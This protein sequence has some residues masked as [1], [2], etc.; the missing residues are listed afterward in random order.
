VANDGR[1]LLNIGGRLKWI[2]LGRLLS[3]TP[4]ELTDRLPLAVCDEAIA[5]GYPRERACGASF[6]QRQGAGDL[7]ALPG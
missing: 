1:N 2:D 4:S 3:A 6:A 5:F 7:I